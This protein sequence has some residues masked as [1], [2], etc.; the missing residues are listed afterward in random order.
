MAE[1]A[2]VSIGSLYQYFPDKRALV[3]AIRERHLQDCLA[4]MVEARAAALPA[5]EFAARLVDGMI[6]THRL[7]PGLHRVLLDEAP[8]AD[9]HRDPNSQFERDYLGHYAAA[10]STYRNRPPSAADQVAALV[11]SD[12]IDGVIHNAAR[13]NRLADPAVRNEL[14]RLIGPY[15]TGTEH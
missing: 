11:L 14:L 5:A 6:A 9:T 10:V 13:R 12:A 15:L 2:G 4:V 7:H 8:S 1:I 3:D